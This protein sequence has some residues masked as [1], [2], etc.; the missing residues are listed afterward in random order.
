MDDKLYEINKKTVQDLCEVILDSMINDKLSREVAEDTIESI[1]SHCRSGRRPVSSGVL[2]A[3]QTD[4][5]DMDYE[6]LRGR[7]IAECYQNE[8][9][10]LKEKIKPNKKHTLKS[11][12][13]K[14]VMHFMEMENTSIIESNVNEITDFFN[15][16]GI[17]LEPKTLSNWYY[18]HKNK[19]S[20]E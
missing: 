4:L 7:Y 11:P 3:R 18:S 10:Q 8:V 14:H 6:I 1:L 15:S 2:K 20:P 13:L 5:T 16:Y 19:V 17:N 9:F 12:L